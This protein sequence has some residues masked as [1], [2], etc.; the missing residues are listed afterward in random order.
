MLGELT[1]WLSEVTVEELPATYQSL[2][3]ILGV[4]LTLKL[5]EELG[6]TSIYL[7]KTDKLIQQ[8]RDRKIRDEFD[9]GNHKTLARRYQLSESR[10]RQ[11]LAETDADSNQLTLFGE[12]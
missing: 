4:E 8:L 11:I 3:R 7:P 2:A 6:G 5:A 1:S 12:S 10:I 9:G